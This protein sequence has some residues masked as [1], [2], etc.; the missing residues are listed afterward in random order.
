MYTSL[1]LLA[2]LGPG[3]SPRV[4]SA[5]ES[6]TWRVSYS[7]APTAVVTSVTRVPTATVG[8]VVSSTTPVLYA[9]SLGAP[10]L[11]YG[12]P[13][14]IVGSIGTTYA[15]VVSGPVYYGS[16]GVRYAPVVS[17]PVYQGRIVTSS[18]PAVSAPV[19][20]GT[21]VTSS[22]PVRSAPVYQGS[23][24]RTYAPAQAAP[25][26]MGGYAPSY[27]FGRASGYCAG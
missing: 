1:V 18:A 17:A 4:V 6:P 21:T 16:V 8:T 14:Q 23:I 9:R 19:Y 20:R 2:T 5:A 13:G 12:P 26:Y 10:V 7:H 11:R 3:A 24:T 25:V 15:P 22:A 27:S